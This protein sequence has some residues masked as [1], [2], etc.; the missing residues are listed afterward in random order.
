MLA[1][2]AIEVILHLFV[3]FRFNLVPAKQRAHTQA[4]HVK[5]MFETHVYPIRAAAQPSGQSS[6][7]AT[8]GQERPTHRPRIKEKRTRPVSAGRSV[9]H[10]REDST[11]F[12]QRPVLLRDRQ[13]PRLQPKARF[14]EEQQR[15]AGGAL[16]PGPCARQIPAF[17]PAPQT[18]TAHRGQELPVRWIRERTRSAKPPEVFDSTPVYRES[19]R[20]CGFAQRSGWD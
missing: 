8:P 15:P 7:R 12:A 9:Q 17:V 6:T 11:D 1:N 13:A 10:R 2:L 14:D 5:Q 19:S 3:Q 20:V 18:T 16:R 4:E